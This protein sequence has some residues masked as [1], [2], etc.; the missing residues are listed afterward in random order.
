MGKV[1]R[2]G[3]VKQCGAAGGAGK[4]AQGSKGRGE[5]GGMGERGSWSSGDDVRNCCPPLASMS[6]VFTVGSLGTSASG[7]D[8]VPSLE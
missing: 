4:L 7:W 6:S 3:G 8:T 2:A 5:A 1:P